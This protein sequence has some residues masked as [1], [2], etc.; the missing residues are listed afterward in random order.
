MP[1]TKL[2][3]R[4]WFNRLKRSLDHLLHEVR[5][6]RACEGKLPHPPRPLVRATATARLLIVGQAPG[7]W[8]HESEIPWNDSSGNRLRE[9]MAINREC[10]YDERRIAIIPMGFCYPGRGRS[11][12]LPPR[13]ECAE[14]WLDQLLDHLPRVQLTL[15]VGQYAQRHYLGTRRKSTL[16]ETVRAWQE[17]QPMFLPLPHPSGRNNAWMRRNRWFELEVLP[18]LRRKCRKLNVV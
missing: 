3:N 11:G 2:H 5:A 8:A 17:Y 1:V 14:L 16:T 4:C 10:F 15:L 9:W 12:D 18:V 13:K 6:C 7:T